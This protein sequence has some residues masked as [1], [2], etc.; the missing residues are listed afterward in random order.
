MRKFVSLLLGALVAP[1]LV[2][3]TTSPADAA[4]ECQWTNRGEYNAHKGCIGIQNY[5]IG[6]SVKG[7]SSSY[8]PPYTVSTSINVNFRLTDSA[9][10]GDCTW[11]R[12]KKTKSPWPFNRKQPGTEVCGK[13][14]YKNINL[15][16]DNSDSAQNMA[17]GLLE[18]QHCK[19][20]LCVTFWKQRIP[21]S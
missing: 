6:S 3:L 10:D 7:G 16:F 5:L 11:I 9:A 1:L 8:E 2:V 17:K 4:I 12:A 20:G 18:I 21:K 13:G 19:P 14:D 15:Y